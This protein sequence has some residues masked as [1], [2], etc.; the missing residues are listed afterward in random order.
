MQGARSAMKLSMCLAFATV[1]TARGQTG[2][3]FFRGK[4]I[5]LFVGY[6][7]GGS[8]DAYSSLAANALPRFIPGAPQILVKHMPG[9]GGLKAANYLAIQASRDGLSIGMVSQTLALRQVLGDAGLEYDAR[10]LNWIGRLAAAVEVTI[11]RADRG[12]RTIEDARQREVVLAATSAG[13]TTDV[14]PRLMNI[15]AGTKFRIVKGYPGTAGATL[16]MERGEAEASHESID[17]LLFN[18]PQWVRDGFVSVLV[19]Y[20]LRR[21]RAFPEIPV[22]V[23]FGKTAAERELLELF[24]GTAEIG[25]ALLAPPGVPEER[26]AILR[27][28]FDAMVADPA[29]R[30]EVRRRNLEVDPLGAEEL[31]AL[32]ARTLDAPEAIVRQA[33]AIGGP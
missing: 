9:V 26:L 17:T 10:K 5:S 14:M 15:H 24:G 20:A 4:Q 31:R 3:P 12:V 28:A 29:F 32:V 16:A 1:A 33:I 19:Q 18:K 22:M 6:N 23:D 25:R 8:Y 2:D 21:H 13:S 30:E 11:S 27:N 7:P